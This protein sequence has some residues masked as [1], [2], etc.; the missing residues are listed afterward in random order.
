MSKKEKIQPSLKLE[1]KS[2]HCAYPWQQMI[3]DLTGEVVPCCFWSGY[4]NHGK[5]LGNTNVDSLKDIW[6]GQA[7]QDLRKRVANNDLRDHPCGNCMSYRWSNGVYPKFSWPAS[8]RNET[9][10]CCLGRIPEEFYSQVKHLDIDIVLL[11]DG[12]PLRYPN[13]THEEIRRVGA[14]RYSIWGSWLYFSSSDNKNPVYSGRRYHLKCCDYTVELNGLNKESKSGVNLINSH[15][16]YL[17]GVEE[18][19]ANPTMITLISTA[20]CNIDC[21]SCSQNLVRITK[22]QHRSSTVPEVIELIPYLSDFIW[23]GGEP[24]LIKKFREFIDGFSHDLN[25]NLTFG[26]TSNGMMITE[27]EAEKLKKFPRLNASVSIDSFNEE[28]FKKIRRGANFQR[29]LE[30]TLRLNAMSDDPKRV[31]S[32]GMIACKSNMHEID[33]NIEFALKHN[34]GLNISP[35]LLY[36]VI[37]QLN[38]FS[39]FETETSG[40]EEAL[41]R[42]KDLVKNAINAENPAILKV[43]PQGMINELIN[44]Y[45]KGKNIYSEIL[46]IEITVED[47]TDSIKNMENP[48]IVAYINNIPLSYSILRS[49]RREYHLHL[50]KIEL[51]RLSRLRF[52]IVHN[53]METQGILAS[54]GSL[55]APRKQRIHVVMPKFLASPWGRNIGWA[56]YGE[57][58]PEGTHI[59]D[60]KEIDD[61]YYNLY[62]K[63]LT[64]FGA[65]IY[66]K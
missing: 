26:F 62:R 32:V 52:N 8:F 42:A 30:N 57:T 23:H 19:T 16:E 49:G 1:A 3:I 46:T 60:P 65:K 20:D 31:F 40:W 12:V 66:Y 34:I 18:V 54:I 64:N 61:V 55:G 37:E 22:I 13:A 58:T 53:V 24:Y 2:N 41:Y 21:P 43:N 7:Y 36:P 29:V 9:G 45:N 38:V 6:N 51:S 39:D 47:P 28:T 25:P 10:Y 33:Q 4:G 5:P 44:L 48:A 17:E 59:T 14:G 27:T 11:E 50:P 35:V 56:N 63:S 15:K